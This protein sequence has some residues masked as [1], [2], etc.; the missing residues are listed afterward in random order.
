MLKAIELIKKY[1]IDEA[2]SMLESNSLYH[3]DTSFR[4]SLDMLILRHNRLNENKALGIESKLETENQIFSSLLDLCYSNS[5]VLKEAVDAKDEDEQSSDLFDISKLFIN[6]ISRLSYRTEESELEDISNLKNLLHDKLFGEYKKAT[7]EISSLRDSY[8]I[9]LFNKVFAADKMTLSLIEEVDL[10]RHDSKSFTSSDRIVIVSGITC[11]LLNFKKFDQK[12]A[13]ILLDFLSDN[14]K[15][16]SDYALVGILLSFIYHD[17]RWQRYPNVKRRI[18]FIQQNPE[19]QSKL[20]DIEYVLAKNLHNSSKFNL[21]FILNIQPL[22]ETTNGLLQDK[23]VRQ[24]VQYSSYSLLAL[25]DT[26]K[27]VRVGVAICYMVATNRGFP[28]LFLGFAAPY[29]GFRV[30]SLG[31]MV[32]GLGFEI[33][34]LGFRVWGLQFRV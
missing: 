2:I 13:L 5:E 16:T 31:F 17:K 23:M 1:R 30:H 28:I 14:E 15:G 27:S 21:T 22:Q 12:K 29:L 18:K 9:R 19:I 7:L 11:S 34:K 32:W 24:Q 20:E 25:F 33:L 4:N 8:S 3:S 26:Y 6:K 10:V